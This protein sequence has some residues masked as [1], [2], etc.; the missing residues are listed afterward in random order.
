MTD[1][2]PMTDLIVPLAGFGSN[3]AFTALLAGVIFQSMTLVWVG[4]LL[5]STVVVFQ[6]V[7]LPVEFDASRRGANS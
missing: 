4:I 5:F 7:N 2:T 6:L 1:L 3:I